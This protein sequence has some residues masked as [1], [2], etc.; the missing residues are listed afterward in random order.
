MKFDI[1]KIFE[2]NVIVEISEIF[3]IFRIP[4]TS[5]ILEVSKKNREKETET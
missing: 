3:E 4:E 1:S 5:E 2:I